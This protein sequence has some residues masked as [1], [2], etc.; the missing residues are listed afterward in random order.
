M[1]AFL[2]FLS[3]ASLLLSTAAALHVFDSVRAPC[4]PERSKQCDSR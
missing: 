3:L 2:P 1:V 4:S